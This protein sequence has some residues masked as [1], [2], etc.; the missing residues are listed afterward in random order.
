MG[1]TRE[2]A[3]FLR[4]L[5][6]CM[7]RPLRFGNEQVTGLL[8]VGNLLCFAKHEYAVLTGRQALTPYGADLALLPETIQ[9]RN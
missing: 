6:A 3:E 9:R 2:I 8:P 5:T 7:P 1:A 4:K